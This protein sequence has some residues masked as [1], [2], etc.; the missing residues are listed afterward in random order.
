MQ[1]VHCGITPIS[2]NIGGRNQ[3]TPISSVLNVDGMTSSNTVN[4]QNLYALSLQPWA[5]FAFTYFENGFFSAHA[6]LTA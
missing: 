6:C 3:D 1:V 5:E 2:V 4:K